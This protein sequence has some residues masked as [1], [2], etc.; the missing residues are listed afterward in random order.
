VLGQQSNRLDQLDVRQRRPDG[1]R[2]S[3]GAMPYQPSA[4]PLNP[5]QVRP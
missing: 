4:G 3:I 1:D 5:S 2:T